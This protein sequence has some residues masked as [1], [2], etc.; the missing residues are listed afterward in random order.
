MK[1]SLTLL[2]TLAL[3][4]CSLTACGGNN[5]QQDRNDD[6]VMGGETADNNMTADNGMTNNGATANNGTTNDSTTD[7]GTGDNLLDDAGNAI[8][9]GVDDVEDTLTGDNNTTSRSATGGISYRQMLENARVHDT[10]GDL[11]D[12]ENAMTPGG[13][14]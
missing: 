10:D 14:L 4:V 9:N 13:L 12:H 1:R 5:D 11:T 8:R 7:N 6:T 2:L 3:L